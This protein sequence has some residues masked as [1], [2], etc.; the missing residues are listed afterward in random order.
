MNFPSH[1]EIKEA[2]IILLLNSGGPNHR[3]ELNSVYDELANHFHLTDEQRNATYGEVQSYSNSDENYWKNAVRTA[4]ARLIDDGIL[5]PN[6]GHGICELIIYKVPPYVIEKSIINKKASPKTDSQDIKETPQ[7][8]YDVPISPISSDNIADSTGTEFTLPDE[9]YDT[10][11]L[12]E[13]SKHQIL[14]NAYERNTKARQTCIAHYGTK[15][16]ICN[17][18]FADKYG[19]IG[20]GYIHVH[21]IKPLSE[22]NE[23]YE[24]NPIHD[25]RPVCPNCHAMLHRNKPALSIDELKNIVFER[26]KSG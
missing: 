8:V 11:S 2:F 19:K 18:D 12:Y 7:P 1:P 25:L 6:P 20:N 10:I 14:V 3:K 26:Q 5:H 22:I 13:G 15:C 16:F 24:I 23:R 21:H 17:F 4:K 9:L